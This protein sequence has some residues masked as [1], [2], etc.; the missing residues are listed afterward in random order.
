MA[1]KKVNKW[2]YRFSVNKEIETEVSEKSKNDKGEEVT[3]TKKVKT[4]EPVWFGLRKP[5]RRLFDEGELFY[6]VQLS[7][8]IK[9]GLLTKALLAKRYENDGGFLSDPEKERYANL[10]V[11]LFEKENELQKVQLNLEK[12]KLKYLK[13]IN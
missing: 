1:T 3:V 8:G 9:A 12:L 11:Q 4:E 6:G 2:L 5:G 7:E 13:N 10:Y